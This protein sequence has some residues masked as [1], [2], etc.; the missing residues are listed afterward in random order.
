MT[1]GT[2]FPACCLVNNT[3]WDGS[4]TMLFSAQT[5]GKLPGSCIFSMLTSSLFTRLSHSFNRRAFHRCMSM[6][7]ARGEQSC[8]ACDVNTDP[9]RETGD[10]CAG[11][12]CSLQR[13]SERERAAVCQGR[14]TQVLA[15][16]NWW[17]NATIPCNHSIYSGERGGKLEGRKS[18][19]IWGKIRAGEH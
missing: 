13:E 18:C 11:G 15:L 19:K 16:R 8:H 5:A 4:N 3:D 9:Q 14:R 2:V 10:E 7:T 6:W 17:N 12:I 1:P